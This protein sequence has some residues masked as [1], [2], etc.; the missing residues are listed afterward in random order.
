MKKRKTSGDDTS[1]IYYQSSMMP[2]GNLKGQAIDIRKTEVINL[3]MPTVFKQTKL[4]ESILIQLQM[5][6]NVMKAQKVTLFVIDTNLQKLI[7]KNK[8]D[9]QMHTKK[10]FINGVNDWV[11]VFQSDDEFYEP[12]FTSQNYMD[13][14]FNNKS[15]MLPI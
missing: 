9:V 10:L 12:V 1:S 2:T 7:T 6:K 5:T 14:V 8:K 3:N 13:I 15:I 4:M 11:A